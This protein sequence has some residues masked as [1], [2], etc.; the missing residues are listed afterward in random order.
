MIISDSIKKSRIRSN[1]Y[2]GR[3]AGLDVDQEV[4]VD[5]LLKTSHPY[6]FAVGDVLDFLVG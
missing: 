6:V 5:N 3:T 4:V 1:T 2:P